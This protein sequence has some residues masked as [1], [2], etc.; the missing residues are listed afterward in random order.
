MTA[1]VFVDTSI[2][3]CALQSS[4]PAKQALAARWLERLWKEQRGRTSMQVLSEC[5]VNLTRKI[6]PALEPDSASLYVQS[7]LKWK[8]QPS[9][10]GILQRAHE[11]ERR[12]GLDS[13]DS[14]IVAAAQAQNCILLLSDAL[15]HN[16]VYGTVTIRNPFAAQVSADIVEDTT[17]A[18]A[19]RAYR[20]RG[21]P[22][23][24]K[25][26]TAR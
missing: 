7:L 2:F 5:Y 10:A 22:R 8:P 23:L 16:A 17:A 13:W 11:I 12:H 3:L 18:I 25:A 14:L 15:A 9:D 26:R 6:V 24:K 4:E 20:A 19:E 1:P 21:R